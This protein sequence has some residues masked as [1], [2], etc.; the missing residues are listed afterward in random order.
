MSAQA[1]LTPHPPPVRW[2]PWASI[3]LASSRGCVYPR[4]CPR[5]SYRQALCKRHRLAD[6]RASPSSEVLGVPGEDSAETLT[7]LQGRH[8]SRHLPTPP[9]TPNTLDTSRPG[10]AWLS[11][12]QASWR[13]WLALC[14]HGLL[15]ARRAGV[16]RSLCLCLLNVL[17]QQSDRGFAGSDLRGG[18]GPPS[19]HSHTDA[20]LSSLYPAKLFAAPGAW[21]LFQPP[22]CSDPKSPRGWFLLAT[23][24]SGQNLHLLKE[25]FLD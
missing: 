20:S 25:C 24:A 7:F 19:F 13:L 16:C 5:C 10:R 22:E 15:T 18:R 23:Q 6:H 1:L 12:R 8:T 17:S 2:P 11:A 9:D 3:P 14:D 21:P 4:Y